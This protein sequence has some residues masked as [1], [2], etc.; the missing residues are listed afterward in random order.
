MKFVKFETR[1]SKMKLENF[2]FV[3]FCEIHASN[4][5]PKSHEIS[6][7]NLTQIFSKSSNDPRRRYEA[8]RRR[9]IKKISLR[10]LFEIFRRSSIKIFLRS[11]EDL[12]KILI[13]DL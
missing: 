5:G 1:N 7:T 3:K 10:V 8:H 2:E 13:E 6:L 12:K 4:P 9:D 11:H